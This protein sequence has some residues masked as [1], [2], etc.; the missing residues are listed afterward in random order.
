MK[1]E[2]RFKIGDK[3]TYKKFKECRK[4]NGVD[5]GYYFGGIDHGGF[6]GEIINNEGYYN[7]EKNCYQISVS[8]KI[9]S[10]TFVMLE[11]EFEE[12]DVVTS[13][14]DLFPIY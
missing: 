4:S 2:P 11:S 5:Y 13:T 3:V 14:N 9:S 12:Y 8:T 10:A 6:V 7:E 1:R